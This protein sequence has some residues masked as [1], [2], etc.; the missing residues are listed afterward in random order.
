M[1]SEII[2]DAPVVGEKLQVIVIADQIAV[3]VAGA[4]LFQRPFLARS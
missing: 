2:A 4:H 3:G 1:F